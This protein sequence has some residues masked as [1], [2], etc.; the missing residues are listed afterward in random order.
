M[1]K[2]CK[3]V[4]MSFKCI[5]INEKGRE[6]ELKLKEREIDVEMNREI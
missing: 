3:R 6:K 1:R 2:I 4:E 5:T